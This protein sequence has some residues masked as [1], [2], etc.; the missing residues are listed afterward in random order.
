MN[1]L[2]EFALLIAVALP[3]ITVLVMNAVLYA[4]G[5]RD[6]LLVPQPRAWPC[7]EIELVH[8]AAP[9]AAARAARPSLD[10]TPGRDEEALPVAA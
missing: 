10:F 6:T 2:H 5:E 4:A 8:A 1:A 3:V 7:L 9:V